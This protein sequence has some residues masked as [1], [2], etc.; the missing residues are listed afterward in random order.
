ML[1]LDGKVVLVTG[2]LTAVGRQLGARL[3]SLGASVALVD[4]QADGSGETLSSEINAGVGRAASIYVQTDL[5]QI[6]DIRLMVDAAVLT[7]GRLDVLVNNAQSIVDQAAGD[8]DVQRVGDSIDVNLRAPVVAT[9]V[10]SR[11]LRQAGSAGVVVNVAAMAG[12][13]PGSG[14]EVYGA[15]NAGLIHFTEAHRR[16]LAPELR[17]CGLAPYYVDSPADGGG[18]ERLLPGNRLGAA[19]TLSSDQVVAAVVRCIQDT[20]LNGRTLLIAG[21]STYTHTWAFLLARLHMFAIMVWS[22]LVLVLQ[23]LVGRGRAD[24]K[25]GEGVSKPDDAASN[26]DEAFAEDAKKTR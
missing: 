21:S 8:E 18:G 2:A 12:L 19:L 1:D 16:N 4:A 10:F 25:A 9:W 24:A 13:V 17:V 14:R 11:Y 23:R 26:L 3:V 6:H 15:A 5:R 20:R 7:F 22:M